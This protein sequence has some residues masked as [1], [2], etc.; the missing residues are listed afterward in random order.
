MFE[1]ILVPVDGSKTMERTVTFACDLVKIM[2]GTLTLLHVVALP[3]PIE[4]M[5]SFDYGPLERYGKTVLE[6]AQKLVEDNG[7]KADTIL[8]TDF[9]NAGHTIA[10][11]ARDKS[12]TLTVIHARGHSRIEGLLLG[13]VCHTVAH[14]SSCS[15]LIV[16][17]RGVDDMKLQKTLVPVDDSP[18]MPEVVKEAVAFAKKSGCTLT[19]LYVMNTPMGASLAR[20]ARE[21]EEQRLSCSRIPDGCR[22]KSAAEGV[23]ASSRTEVGSPAETVIN[24]AEREKFD[25]IIMGSRGHSHLRTLLVGSVADQV[26]EHASCPVLLLK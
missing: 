4:P 26:M 23:S 6:K 18:Y 5:G 21:M 14:R 8:E 17:H 3:I 10:R 22:Q 11:M 16:R 7:C 13:S 12:F 25:M 1:K 19:F 2:G 15:V 24:V 9:G 20:S